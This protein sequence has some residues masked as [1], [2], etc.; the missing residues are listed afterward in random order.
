VTWF[1]LGDE[2]GVEEIE[3]VGRI[4]IDI[5]DLRCSVFDQAIRVEA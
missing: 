3:P 2:G 4:G 5:F 1:N